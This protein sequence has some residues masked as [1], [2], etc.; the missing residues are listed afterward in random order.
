VGCGDCEW[1]ATVSVGIA[2]LLEI[3]VLCAGSGN[4]T[5]K[6]VL[7]EWS[8]DRVYDILRGFLR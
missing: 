6:P 8:I 7:T 2:T 3:A 1:I 4:R 5:E